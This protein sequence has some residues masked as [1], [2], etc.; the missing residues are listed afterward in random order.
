MKFG[1]AEIFAFAGFLLAI[2]IVVATYFLFYR[3][4][5][6]TQQEIALETQINSPVS[7]IA[8]Q[9]SILENS[10]IVEE[11]DAEL[12]E[13]E[14][15][16]YIVKSDSSK[17][18]N[19]PVQF[20]YKSHYLP[21]KPT[22]EDYSFSWMEVKL[23]DKRAAARINKAIWQE[24]KGYLESD[25]KDQNIPGEY[26]NGKGEFE[27]TSTLFV[28]GN[29]LHANF[30]QYSFFEGAAHPNRLV[31]TSCFDMKSGGQLNFHDLIR[32][33][34]ISELDSLIVHKTGQEEGVTGPQL[35]K[36]YLEQLSDLNFEF[37]KNG[38]SLILRGYDYVTS[39]MML[40][41]DLDKTSYFLKPEVFE[42]VYKKQNSF[43]R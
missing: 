12:E 2:I 11:Q 6:K 37:T 29:L 5:R 38:L 25:E 27:F 9:D 40:E 23:S 22:C 8:N 26:C 15:I 19:N 31:T 32:P 10:D 1:K 36:A 24:V 3:K 39:I 33:E 18:S 20:I 28:Y 13:A 16:P 43:I 30:H 34:R 42:M 21:T 17:A 14:P 35:R 4:E 7:G 41:L